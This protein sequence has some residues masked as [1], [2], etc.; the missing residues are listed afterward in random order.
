MANATTAGWADRLLTPP[1]FEHSSL[2]LGPA[3]C[4]FIGPAQCSCNGL[5]VHVLGSR[6]LTKSELA[7]YQR[8]LTAATSDERCAQ[9]IHSVRISGSMRQIERS[10]KDER[11]RQLKTDR[12]GYVQTFRRAQASL[13]RGARP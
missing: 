13:A 12:A 7:Y 6:G 3:E 11:I 4:R 5:L 1:R 8:A 2:C 9:I 10:A